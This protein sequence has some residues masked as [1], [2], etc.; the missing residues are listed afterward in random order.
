[1]IYDIK[2]MIYDIKY[3]EKCDLVIHI[4]IKYY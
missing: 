4:T 1:M 2:F 3:A